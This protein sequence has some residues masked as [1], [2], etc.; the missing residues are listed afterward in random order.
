MFDRQLDPEQN[1]S[2]RILNAVLRMVH[3]HDFT[4]NIKAQTCS[5]GV[6]VAGSVG[7][8]KCFK[9]MGKRILRY[10]NSCIF[11][12]TTNGIVSLG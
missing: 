8:V 9:Q 3:F 10:V 7:T 1:A 2:F 6:A 5:A 4:D 11:N 12:L